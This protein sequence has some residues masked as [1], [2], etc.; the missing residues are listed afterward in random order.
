MKKN[1]RSALLSSALSLASMSLLSRFSRSL[2]CSLYHS[3]THSLS[4]SLSL[5]LSL[6]HS[7]TLSLPR[8]RVCW[9]CDLLWAWLQESFVV[10]PEKKKKENPFITSTKKKVKL[11]TPDTIPDQAERRRFTIL[12]LHLPASLP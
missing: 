2:A 1:L 4:H 12:T 9:V 7:L 6:S 3:L 11:T 8:V 10:R 5:S